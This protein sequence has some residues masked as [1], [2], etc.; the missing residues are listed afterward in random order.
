MVPN[1]VITFRDD[2]DNVVEQNHKEISRI[3]ERGLLITKIL[4]EKKTREGI[5]YEVS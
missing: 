2:M 5:I 3:D 4:N 1:I